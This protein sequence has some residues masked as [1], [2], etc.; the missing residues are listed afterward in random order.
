V[1]SGQITFKKCFLRKFKHN[2]GFLAIKRVFTRLT[3]LNIHI[4]FKFLKIKY[5]QFIYICISFLSCIIITI[6]SLPKIIY[7]IKI[8]KKKICHIFI[9]E[10]LN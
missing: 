4:L 9:D 1:K 5:K 2:N 6:M 10:K 8:D 3:Y 7:Y